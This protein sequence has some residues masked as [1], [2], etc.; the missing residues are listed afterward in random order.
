MPVA[1]HQAR[2]P[3]CGAQGWEVLHFGSEWKV[4]GGGDQEELPAGPPTSG[5]R[6]PVLVAHC[7]LDLRQLLVLGN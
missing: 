7:P 5:T 6:T 4:I 1:A 3:R 2:P